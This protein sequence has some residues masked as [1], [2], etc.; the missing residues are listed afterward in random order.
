MKFLIS[1]LFIVFTILFSSAGFAFADWDGQEIEKQVGNYT[2]NYQY[3]SHMGADIQVSTPM[4]FEFEL[5]NKDHTKPVDFSDVWVEVIP[6]GEP[7]D[8]RVYEAD[9]HQKGGETI[10]AYQFE[11]TGTYAIRMIFYKGDAQLVETT[12]SV[13]VVSK[14]NFM[15]NLNI[16]FDLF[17]A[18]AFMCLAIIL[19]GKFELGGGIARRLIRAIALIGGTGILSYFLGH[20]SLLYPMGMGLAG[21]TFHVL[22]CWKNGIDPLTA[23]PYD[24]YKKLRGWK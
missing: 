15:A 13:N 7:Q 22:W 14:N 11:K 10:M 4:A 19:F 6:P 9:L 18:A 17:V 23:E 1:S 2:V 8:N 20:W 12:V 24:L 5:W 16:Y 3:D 21:A